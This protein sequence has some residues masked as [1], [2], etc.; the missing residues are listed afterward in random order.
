MVIKLS[1]K[2]NHSSCRS[3]ETH[4]LRFTIINHQLSLI[5][6]LKL[7]R[8]QWLRQKY[9]TIP[10]PSSEC[11]PRSSPC[12]V[13]ER[14]SW[15]RSTGRSC[16]TAPLWLW[17]VATVFLL[18]SL[19]SFNPIL[20]CQPSL[21]ISLPS[22]CCVTFQ[23]NGENNFDELATYRCRCLDSNNKRFIIWGNATTRQ[24]HSTQL[25]TCDEQ[26]RFMSCIWLSVHIFR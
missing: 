15:L 26:V 21:H 11:G 8:Q 16:R 4:S 2:Y 25:S 22:L 18:G 17:L 10:E 24:P 12:F 14:K 3:S 6:L 19:N 1:E 9:I 13:P 5:K 7:V 23:R 20:L